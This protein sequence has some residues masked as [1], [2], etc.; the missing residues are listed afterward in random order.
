MITFETAKAIATSA[1]GGK[2]LN[3]YTEYDKAW[4]F[5]NGDGEY[6]GEPGVAIL[7]Q[8]GK[9]MTLTQLILNHLPEIVKENQKL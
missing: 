2:G 8:N 4:Y 9:T 5:F 6:D 7:K 3:R 1:A